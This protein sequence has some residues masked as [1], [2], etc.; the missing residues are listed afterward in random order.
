[1][2]KQLIKAIESLEFEKGISKEKLISAVES[3]LAA[4]IGRD[5]ESTPKNIEVRIDPESGEIVD[6]SSDDGQSGGL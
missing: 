6:Q 5:V 3:A 1:M 4:A 2:N